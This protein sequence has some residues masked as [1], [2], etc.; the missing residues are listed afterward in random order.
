M[1]INKITSEI[2]LAAIRVHQQLGPGLLESVYQRC[3]AV[4]L[5]ERKIL[6][7]QEC[8]V[9]I[10]YRGQD[11][12]EEGFRLDMLVA[13]QVVVELKSVERLQ[14]I[15][16]KQTLTYLRLT[17]KPLGLLINFNVTLLK[18]G[19]RRIANNL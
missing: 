19:I 15:H 10:C 16:F 4:E 11:I 1:D 18:D 12:S 13:D 6:F 17:N 9:P 8:P 7:E 2:V 5:T 3:L 14:P